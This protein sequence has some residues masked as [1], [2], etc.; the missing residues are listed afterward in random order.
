L[1]GKINETETTRKGILETFLMTQINLTTQ[2]LLLA[3]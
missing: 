2:S 1:N 3:D